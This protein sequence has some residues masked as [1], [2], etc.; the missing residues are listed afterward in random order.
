M[1]CAKCGSKISKFNEEGNVCPV[2][3]SPITLTAFDKRLSE[4]DVSMK[5][6][7]TFMFTLYPIIIFITVFGIMGNTNDFMAVFT[8]SLLL[9]LQLF[10][11]IM[12]MKLKKTGIILFNVFTV[13]VLYTFVSYM[14]TALPY[15]MEIL[16]NPF[17]SITFAFVLFQTITCGITSIYL[18][19]RKEYF[20]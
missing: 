2:C 17:S 5:W 11:Y 10:S 6:F 1:Y 15:I 7:K 8:S 18:W 12:L 4:C 14:I 16:Y 20:H 13:F 19:K 3:G 9:F